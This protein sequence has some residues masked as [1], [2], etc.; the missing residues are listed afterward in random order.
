MWD[1]GKQGKRL[2]YSAG[3]INSEILEKEGWLEQDEASVLLYR[4][5]RNNIT[6][7]TEF[8]LGIKLFPF[9]AVLIKALFVSDYT[10]HVLARGMSKTFSTAIYLI[11]ELMFNQ[12]CNIGVLAGT[13]R[14]S[15]MIFTKI[16]DILSKPSAK[17]A[18]DCIG[19][20]NLIQKGTDQWT[21]K[22]GRSR[23][24]ALPLA[25]GE[26]LRGFR[27][28]I[29]VIDEF[30]T[31]P[32]KI[33]NEVIMPFLGVI[34]NPTERKELR[35]LET[36]L[37]SQGKMTEEE[38]FAWP[39]NKLILLSS[40]SFKFEYM[41]KLYKQFIDLILGQHDSQ[42]LNGLEEEMGSSSAYRSVFQLSY[43]L[44][45]PELYDQN[46]L[47]QAKATMSKAQ[48]DREFGA[49]FGDEGDSYFKMSRMMQCTVAEGDFPAVE[50]IGNPTEEY[51]LAFDPSW[52]ESEEADFFSMHVGKL[53]R[54]ENKVAI[55]HSFALTGQQLKTYMTYFHYLYTHFNV[56]GIVGDRNGGLQFISSC[57]ESELFKNSKIEIKYVEGDFDKS[58]DYHADLLRM[59]GSINQSEHK[60]CFL[61]NPSSSWIR[62]ANEMLQASIDHKRIIFASGAFLG[63]KHFEEQSKADVPIK[64]LKWE[65][66]YRASNDDAC[67]VD[68]IDY[69]KQNIELTKIQT[70]N[71][72]VT[73]SPQGTQSF[74]LPLHMRKQRGP[75]RPRKD[76]YS[77]LVLLN[78]WAK[79][80]FDSLEVKEEKRVVST[81]VPFTI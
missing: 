34:E 56:V 53:L 20:K 17:L 1:K 49:Q 9:Q 14:Q 32:E 43:D 30:L 8:F 61:R 79:V 39:N 80:Y 52:S 12:G 76:L 41:Y 71:I 42:R 33:F 31:M 28:N 62:I 67:K 26:R 25:N 36:R 65:P 70:S 5:L 68:L 69:C 38:R 16:E 47:N 15:K 21:L 27:F 48:F 7:A 40:P 44:A 63:D 3:L 51:I 72:E 46:L 75:N 60:I 45:P 50:I 81:F 54:S 59:K 35:D 77:S 55:V 6:F 23:A 4:F 2:S 18:M 29:I 24:I 19:S 22:I 64:D 66:E 74:D 13:F 58:E 78:W 10:M 73:T 11:L 57:N 37:I